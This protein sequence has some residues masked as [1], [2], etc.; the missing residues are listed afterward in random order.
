MRTAPRATR[1][2]PARAGF[3]NAIVEPLSGWRDH[4][5]SRGV[6]LWELD[7]EYGRQ[8]SSPLARGLPPG[9]PASQA[10]A[11]IIPARAGFTGFLTPALEAEG[12]HPRS[13]GVY[14]PLDLPARGAV[15]SSPL[16]RGLL[17]APH[18]VLQ[19]RRII[20]ARAGFTSPRP[21][22]R[23]GSPDHPRS[24]GVYTLT[25]SRALCAPGSSPL[26]R[27]LLSNSSIC[28]LCLWIIPARAGFTYKPTQLR[29]FDA[30]H[31]RSRGVYL[32][33]ARNA[34]RF[35]G[36]SPL[37]RGLLDLGHGVVHRERIIPARAG[38]TAAL[39]TTAQTS[40]DHPRSRG[41]YG[42]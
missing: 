14:D 34:L 39:D 25:S 12:D 18:V 8:G 22:T 16:A 24:R 6:Y 1:I 23:C 41:V 15:G 26:A 4:P 3:T 5:R 37:A 20:P 21:G 31:P 7:P 11:G 9:P 2:I 33:A 29:R 36:S 35:I 38:F 32:A 19:R 42:R 27:G 28:V 17:P 13:R 10:S 30:D 40:A